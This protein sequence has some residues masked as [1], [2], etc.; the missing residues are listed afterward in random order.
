MKKL[1]LVIIILIPMQKLPANPLINVNVEE[2]ELYEYLSASVE[3][4]DATATI[5]PFSYYNIPP[6]SEENALLMNN[7]RGTGYYIAPVTSISAKYYYTSR[8]ES[9]IEGESGLRLSKGSNLYLFQEGIISLGEHFACYLE[10]REQYNGG[11]DGAY[12][13]PNRAYIKAMAGKISFEGG[14][15][16]V[17]IGPGEYG[18]LLSKNIAPYPM[19]KIQTERGLNLFGSWY[20]M[21]MHGWLLEQREDHSNPK[22]AGARISYLPARWVELGATRTM[23]YGGSGRVKYGFGDIWPLLTGSG[24]NTP[25]SKYDNEGLVAVD[26]SFNIPMYRWFD[27]L[28]IVKLYYQCF[29]TD[30][31]LPWIKNEEKKSAGKWTFP[32]WDRSHM[33]GIN[34]ITDRSFIAL[35]YV[36]TNESYLINHNY[37]DEG[38]TYHGLSIGYPYGRDTESLIL[39]HHWYLTERLSLEYRFGYAKSPVYQNGSLFERWYQFLLRDNNVRKNKELQP[40]AY[41]TFGSV[42][43]GYRFSNC[44]IETYMR[45]DGSNNY[46]D[47]P[48]PAQVKITERDTLFWT[49]GTAFRFFI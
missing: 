15:D 46:D 11:E 14:I 22:L 44:I 34:F 26:L 7:S 36:V 25:G 2:R 49:A 30:V 5:Q 21:I 43:L 29:A 40:T 4:N 12:A 32:L 28:R 23:M 45:L 6:A 1:I 38:Y 18:A 20:F 16:N 17:N 41:S 31:A 48:S 3:Y 8:D 39:R 42:E 35:E 24:E 33:L 10:L 19:V 37:P 13:A 47:N 27:S 9:F